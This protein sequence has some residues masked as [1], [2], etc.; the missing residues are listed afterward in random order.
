MLR[1]CDPGRRAG[2]AGHGQVRVVADQVADGRGAV[3]TGLQLQLDERMVLAD[4]SGQASDHRVRGRPG[5]GEADAAALAVVRRSHGFARLVVHLEDGACGFDQGATGGSEL[6]LAG[7]P[8]EQGCAQVVLEG[9]HG[10]AEV[11]LGEVQPLGGL[12]EVQVLRDGEEH[13]QLTSDPPR[14]LPTIDA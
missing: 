12:P 13:A 1:L 5:E 14:P 2:E 9:A 3:A 4:G 7:G 6:D 8:G 10:S 11:G